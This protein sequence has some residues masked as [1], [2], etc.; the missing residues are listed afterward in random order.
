MHPVRLRSFQT[1]REFVHG[2]HGQ[3][4]RWKSRLLRT[5]SEESHDRQNGEQ[6]SHVISFD[7]MRG[8]NSGT[9]TLSPEPFLTSTTAAPSIAIGQK[10]IRGAR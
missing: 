7:I 4:S 5:D 3:D 1:R 9:T 6:P 2:D 10:R 8:S